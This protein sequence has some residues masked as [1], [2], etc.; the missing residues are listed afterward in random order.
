V[1]RKIMMRLGASPQCFRRPSPLPDPYAHT[2][3]PRTPPANGPAETA[4]VAAAGG[5][6]ECFTKNAALTGIQ[7]DH[8]SASADV[9]HLVLLTRFTTGVQVFDIALQSMPNRG[10]IETP[11][12]SIA[13][14]L[15]AEAMG[16]AIVNVLAFVMS[17]ADQSALLL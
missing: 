7:T 12:A 17:R 9:T 10:P 5:E 16:V 13:C 3:D 6:G 11:M 2:F 1:A 4:G 15:V 14:S 8:S